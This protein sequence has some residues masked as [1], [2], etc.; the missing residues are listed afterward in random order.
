MNK[1]CGKC[2]KQ[3]PVEK[4]SKFKSTPDGLA[5]TCKDCVRDNDKKR[6][7]DNKQKILAQQ[8]QYNDTHKVEKAAYDRKYR[9]DRKQLNNDPTNS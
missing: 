7:K 8:K 5:Y 6:Y 1:Q 4:F 2:N 3:Q 9:E